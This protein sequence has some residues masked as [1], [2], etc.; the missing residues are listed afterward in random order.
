ML[1]LAAPTV[2]FADSMNQSMGR[3]RFDRGEIRLTDTIEILLDCEMA[4]NI[5]D[6][7][8]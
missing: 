8:E 6:S 2:I 3:P 1:I 5:I 7:G 4:A